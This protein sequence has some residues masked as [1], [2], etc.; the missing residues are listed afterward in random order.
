MITIQVEDAHS[1]ELTMP[2]FRHYRV[3]G[4][5]ETIAKLSCSHVI[6]IVE[7]KHNKIGS[8]SSEVFS[9]VRCHRV[10]HS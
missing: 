1:S 9:L 8:I 4:L 7:D 5:I 6:G 3:Q 10:V 2:R